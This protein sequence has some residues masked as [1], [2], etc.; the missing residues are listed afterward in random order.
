MKQTNFTLPTIAD[1]WTAAG[2]IYPV[3][4]ETP[5]VASPLAAKLSGATSVG[6]KLELLQPTGSFK[7]RGAANTILS[8][9]DAEK[10]RGVIT[11]STGNHGRA[12]SYVAHQVGVKAVVCLSKRV[13][14]YRIEAIKELGGTPVVH[15]ASQDEA[16]DHYAVLKEQQG[17]VPVV[18]FDD[19]RVVAGQGTISLEILRQNPS[20]DTLLVP[21]SGGGLLSGMAMAIKALKPSVRVIGI[22]IVRSPAMLESLKIGRPAD[23]EEKDTLADSLLGGIG[24]ENHVT[25]ELVKRHVDEHVLVD[26]QDIEEGMRYLFYQHGLVAEGAASVGLAAI[27]TGKVDVRGCNVVMPLTGR[28]VDIARFLSVIAKGGETR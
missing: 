12:V 24:R 23:I 19:P 10:A 4:S 6:L 3:V 25:M 8:L 14:A 17:L 11:F 1:V 13:P 9:S 20:V 2:R 18:P 27:L 16:E 22:S 28:N 15:G 7:V 21:L 26:E 5:I